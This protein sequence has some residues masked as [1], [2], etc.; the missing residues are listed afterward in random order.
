[1]KI[2]PDLR[3]AVLTDEEVAASADG[4]RATVE[5]Y[6]NAACRRYPSNLLVRYYL[7]ARAETVYEVVTMHGI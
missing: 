7:V 5:A 4:G 2:R 1:M 3:R 6:V